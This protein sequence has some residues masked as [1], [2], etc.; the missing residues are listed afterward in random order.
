VRGI[1]IVGPAASELIG[2]AALAMRLEATA[3]EIAAT[4]HAHPTV[5]EA[6]LEGAEGV[7]GVATHT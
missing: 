4:V 6:I 7:L 3:A 5:S 1:H 2:E